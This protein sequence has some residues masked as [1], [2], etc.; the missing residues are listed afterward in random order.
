[1]VILRLVILAAML[2]INGIIVSGLAFADD[3]GDLRKQIQEIKEDYE[4]KIEQ[5]Q[6]QVNA[7]SKSQEEKVAQIQKK[8]EDRLI[9]TEYVGRYEGPF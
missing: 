6:S 3:I 8:V 5:L 2:I 1:M 9:T 7:L 4:A